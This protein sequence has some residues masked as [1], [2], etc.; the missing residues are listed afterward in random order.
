MMPDFVHDNEESYLI[1]VD[2]LHN[3][4]VDIFSEIFHFSTLYISHYESQLY[5]I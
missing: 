1:S 4:E 3:T 2:A 5:G